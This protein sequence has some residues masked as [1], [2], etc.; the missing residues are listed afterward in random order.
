MDIV[1][2]QVHVFH[3]MSPEACLF[4]MDALGVRSVLI[5]EIWPGEADAASQPYQALP[6]GGHRPLAIGGRMASMQHPDR[7]K[8]LLRVNPNDPDL[9]TTVRLAG[10]DPHCLALRAEVW[11]PQVEAFAAGGYMPLFKAA[12]DAG[13]P[14][15]VLTFGQSALLE[16]YLDEVRDGRFVIDHLGLVKTQEAWDTVLRLAEH[17]N[18]SLKWAHAHR[19][20]A[21]GDYP[22]APLQSALRQAVDAYGA[23]RVL[24]ASDATML[25]EG[26]SWADALFYVREC[27]LLSRTEREWV[28]G[29]SARKLLNW[30]AATA[31]N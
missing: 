12:A 1:D 11:K 25:V 2:A 15:F 18:L 29:R 19:A 31:A 13:L 16:P 20:F 10:E 27:E 23:E 7:F 4:A 3:K 24:W 22:Y 26:V 9:A 17:R 14:T 6:S 30:P 21:A 8:Y 5:D 28:L